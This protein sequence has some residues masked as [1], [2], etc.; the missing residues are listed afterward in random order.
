MARISDVQTQE[1]LFKLGI[2]IQG[3]GSVVVDRQKLNK[4]LL[5]EATGSNLGARII[6][7]LRDQ[8]IDLS[9]MTESTSLQGKILSAV[10]KAAVN[11]NLQGNSFVQESALGY[12]TVEKESIGYSNDLK[13]DAEGHK[14]ECRISIRAF[15]SI[16]PERLKNATF[17][18]QRAYLLQNKGALELFGYRI[19]SQSKAS[20]LYLQVVDVLP[21][22]VGDTIVVPKEIRATTGGDYDIDKLFIHRYNL[23][24]V[25]GVLTKVG[26]PELT[27]DLGNERSAIDS[28]SKEQAQNLLLDLY[29]SVLGTDVYAA[30]ARMPID[31]DTVL[32]KGVVNDLGLKEPTAGVEALSVTSPAYQAEVKASYSAGKDGIPPYAIAIKLHSIA[33]AAGLRFRESTND[34]VL[35]VMGIFNLDRIVGFD[36]VPISTWLSGSGSAMV[37]YAKDPVYGEA[38][39]NNFYN[40]TMAFMFRLG[41]GGSTVR[42]MAQPIFKEQYN[43]VQL[44][45][46]T[47]GLTE[48]EIDLSEWQRVAKAKSQTLK[49]LETEMKR[50]KE[51]QTLAAN[52][53][54]SHV[55]HH[56]ELLERA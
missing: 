55:F 1:V 4:A 7:A 16:I 44:A 49:A 20:A 2:N 30:E 50:R 42:F 39:F 6:Q 24:E 10:V 8:R 37:D 33:T 32:L 19:P 22:T 38:N 56:S 3:D 28:F 15:E 46:R 21:A 31:S 9:A 23:V 45:N 13:Y 5:K 52:F 41:L 51:F 29:L 36:G 11:T 18:E 17:A 12:E 43:A 27:D 25:D 47:V 14:M 26:Y 53:E 48:A 54:D 40:P 35:F 34:N